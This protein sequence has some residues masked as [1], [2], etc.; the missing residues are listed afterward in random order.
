MTLI[1]TRFIVKIS[2]GGYND[3]YSKPALPGGTVMKIYEVKDRPQLLIAALTQVWESSVRAT[4]LFL[5]DGE[6]KN[7]REYVPHALIEVPHLIVACE[8]SAAP[9]AFM[10]ISRQ[11][12]EM[13]FVSPEMRGKG[14]GKKLLLFGIENYSLN[15]LTVNEQNP[16]AC[17][18]YEHM[19]FKTYRRT[20]CDE[21][22]GPYPLLYMKLRNT[23][24]T[25][26][27]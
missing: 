22:G 25:G 12:L 13:L 19:G 4:H 5:S 15:E 24:N 14:L 3:K 20:E 23:H 6:I 18:F 17:G 11:K 27:F 7:I 16:L 10:S 26:K 1:N 9:I 21:E 8:N 2:A